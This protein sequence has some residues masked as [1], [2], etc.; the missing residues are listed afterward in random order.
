MSSLHLDSLEIHNFRGLR[1]LRIEKLGRANLIVGKNNVGKTSV[2]E[3]LRFYAHPGS[4]DVL[5]D[6]LD[7]MNEVKGPL[8]PTIGPNLLPVENLSIEAIPSGIGVPRPESRRDGSVDWNILAEC[9]RED[10]PP[11][12]R[13]QLR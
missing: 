2:L 4:T 9:E 3:A 10:D 8:D 6:V 13:R 12:K 5:L 1:D 11:Q 7:A